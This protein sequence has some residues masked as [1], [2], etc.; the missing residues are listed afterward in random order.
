MTTHLNAIIK[1]NNS[2]LDINVKTYFYKKYKYILNIYLFKNYFY[3]QLL[4]PFTDRLI[5]QFQQ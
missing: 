1:I 5:F 3:S 2:Y 4:Y